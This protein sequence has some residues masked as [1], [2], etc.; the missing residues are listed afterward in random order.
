LSHRQSECV[1]VY[2]QT[3]LR[4]VTSAIRD[5]VR[6]IIIILLGLGLWLVYLIELRD[7]R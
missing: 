2:A 5:A 6:L 7:D 3:D 4:G 1:T